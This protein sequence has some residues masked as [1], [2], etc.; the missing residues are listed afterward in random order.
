[1]ELILSIAF[2]TIEIT[3]LSNKIKKLKDDTADGVKHLT[4]KYTSIV[5][6]KL[7]QNIS[8]Q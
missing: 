7:I 1:M 2:L 6:Y 5:N 8:Q 3:S 4:T